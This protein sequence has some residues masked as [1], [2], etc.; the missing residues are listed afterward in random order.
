MITILKT[1]E[2]IVTYDDIACSYMS[3]LCNLSRSNF[4][5]KIEFDDESDYESDYEYNNKPN[6]NHNELDHSISLYKHNNNCSK[7]DNKSTVKQ[8]GKVEKKQKKDCTEEKKKSIKVI[9]V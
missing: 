4:N 6:F 2:E 3:M 1:S 5:N 8:I 9:C 7:L